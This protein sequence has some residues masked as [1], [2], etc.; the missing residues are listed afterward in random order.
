V[1][2]IHADG[3]RGPTGDLGRSGTEPAADRNWVSRGMW[4]VDVG[5]CMII[6]PLANTHA[7]EDGNARHVSTSAWQQ[8]LWPT[9]ERD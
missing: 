3:F 8:R 6:I 1:Y 9:R 4:G 2:L 5:V 7:K